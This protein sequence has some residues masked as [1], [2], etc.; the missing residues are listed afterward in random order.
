MSKVIEAVLSNKQGIPV[1]DLGFPSIYAICFIGRW[2]R[3]LLA[4]NS[5]ITNILTSHTANGPHK[6]G[7]R[8]L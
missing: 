5:I 7:R 6:A 4:A 1:D 2:S 3:A 8:K